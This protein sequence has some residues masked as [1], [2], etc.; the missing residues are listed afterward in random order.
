VLGVHPGET[1]R[2]NYQSREARVYTGNAWTL[3]WLR[4]S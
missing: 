1:L 2:A 4:T 3:R